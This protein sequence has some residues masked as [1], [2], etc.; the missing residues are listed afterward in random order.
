MKYLS[1][2]LV[3]LLAPLPAFAQTPP[4]AETPELIPAEPLGKVMGQAMCENPSSFL[5]AGSAADQEAIGESFM[6]YIPELSQTYGQDVTFA[7]LFS[8]PGLM[9][10]PPESL[11]AEQKTYLETMFRSAFRHLVADDA[12]FEVFFEDVF[13]E[14]AEPSLENGEVNNPSESE[15]DQSEIEEGAIEIN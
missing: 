4:E 3:C 10:T 11:K 6:T 9:D 5:A 2:F 12:C 1:F 15:I 8:L 7:T 14:R 13:L